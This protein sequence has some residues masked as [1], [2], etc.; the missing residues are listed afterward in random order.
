MNKDEICLHL[1]AKH[2][3]LFDW[4]YNQA[5][6][7]WIQGPKNK[8]TLGQHVLHLNQSIK[9]LNKALSYPNF[10]IKYK[11]GISNRPSRSYDEVAKRYEEKL[12]E[13]KERARV[14][15]KDLITPQIQ[16]Q[17]S[18]IDSLTIQNKKLQYKT[19]KLRDKQLD[20]LLLPHPLMGKMT[21]REI[22]MW[23]VYHTDHHLKI[24]IKNYQ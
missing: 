8:W 3:E 24:L 12:A 20:T 13:N 21:L 14:F 11:F 17:K 10:M 9:M 1:E 5:D 22:I 19:K 2:N 15:N 7:K 4:L 23:T 18:V 16:E 6:E